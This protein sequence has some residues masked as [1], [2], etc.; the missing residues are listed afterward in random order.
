M[1]DESRTDPRRALGERGEE[2]A[3]QHLVESGWEIV[4]RNW[5]V[6]LGEVDIIASREEE[7]Y[8]QVI[9]QI[10]FVEVKTR[11]ISRRRRAPEINVTFKK[12]K[13]LVR[14]ATLW[15]K[16]AAS[17]ANPSLRFD[18]IAVEIGGDGEVIIRHIE[19]AFDARGAC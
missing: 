6:S 14:L 15:L 18:V 5:S 2:L 7:R 19:R 12:R 17:D 9:A 3:A 4:A 13:Q 10:A 8:G 11:R 16:I 1:S